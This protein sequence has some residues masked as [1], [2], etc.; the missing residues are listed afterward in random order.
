M[1]EKRCGVTWVM[2][3][4][5]GVEVCV[6][7]CLSEEMW[8]SEQQYP[9]V[10]QQ[11]RASVLSP[12]NQ[13]II[14]VIHRRSLQSVLS[15]FQ[16]SQCVHLNQ[17]RKRKIPMQNRY[18]KEHFPFNTERTSES[19][20]HFSTKYNSGFCFYFC[21]C[22]IIKQTLHKLKSDLLLA[23]NGKTWAPIKNIYHPWSVTG[24]K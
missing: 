7:G 11:W 1:E 21:T 12:K 8:L 18:D 22:S 17:L 3:V 10:V 4:G 20:T 6:C 24:F 13:N 5:S 14:T 19:V 23:V 2:R 15:I 16:I 9:S